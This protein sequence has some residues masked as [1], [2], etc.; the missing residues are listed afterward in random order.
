MAAQLALKDVLQKAINREIEY[1]VFFFIHLFLQIFHI[2]HNN[3]FHFLEED[4]EYIR[5]KGRRK[6]S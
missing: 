4:Q 6:S 1:V 5:N 2:L 3:I